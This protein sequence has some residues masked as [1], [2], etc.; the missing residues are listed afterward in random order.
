MQ[1]ADDAGAQSVKFVFDPTSIRSV[2]D[3]T[4]IRS[5][6]DP[7]SIRSDVDP[8]SIRSVSDPNGY[9]TEELLHDGLAKFQ[10]NKCLRIFLNIFECF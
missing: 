3:R 9:G 2:S 6:V 1:N 8:T 4:G 5:D 7:T 10:V